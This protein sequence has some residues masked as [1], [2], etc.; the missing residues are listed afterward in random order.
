[1]PVSELPAKPSKPSTPEKTR[2][3]K[4]ELLEKW[5]AI[6]PS[7]GALLAEA[8]EEDGWESWEGEEDFEEGWDDVG[9]GEGEEGEM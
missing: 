1:M 5:V 4:A 2:V 7:P 9:E 6:S 3:Y 8:R